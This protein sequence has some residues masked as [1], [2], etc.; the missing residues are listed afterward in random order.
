[1]DPQGLLGKKCMPAS[2][3]VIIP[4]SGGLVRCW[5]ANS[6]TPTV[7][8]R[9]VHPWSKGLVH[10]GRVKPTGELW[11]LTDTAHEAFGETQEDV[12]AVGAASRGKGLMVV[13][14]PQQEQCHARFADRGVHRAE[15]PMVADPV[16]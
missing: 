12:G 14:F 6:H 1:M 16:S 2:E 10:V 3:K 15:V 7:M 11:I 5:G 8:V 4:A 13:Y 9:G